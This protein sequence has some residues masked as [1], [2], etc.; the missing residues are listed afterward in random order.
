V[1]SPSKDRGAH[2]YLSGDSSMQAIFIASGAAIKKGV[3][4][5]QVSN[6]DIAPTIAALLGLDMNSASGHTIREILE[7]PGVH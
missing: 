7:A 4:L 3:R 6:V 5:S 1:I 2:G